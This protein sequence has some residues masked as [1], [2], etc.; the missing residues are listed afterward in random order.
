M[1]DDNKLKNLFAAYE[2]ELSSEAQ[3]MERLQRKMQAVEI[4]KAKTAKMRRRNRLAVII[5]AI[6]GF[7]TGASFTLCYPYLLN[8]VND[9]ASASAIMASMAA[10]YGNIAIWTVIA[11]ITATLSF[12]AYDITLF[13][14]ASKT[15]PT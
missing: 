8:F 2:P 9:I 11:T 6:T 10:S 5:A 3:F 7:I 4:L 15:N 13:A 14:A 12:T 1:N